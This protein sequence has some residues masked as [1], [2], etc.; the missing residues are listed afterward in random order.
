M[1][2]SSMTSLLQ[3]ELCT[4]MQRVC[5]PSSLGLAMT[6]KCYRFS[7]GVKAVVQGSIAVSVPTRACLLVA[8]TR[9]AGV[10]SSDTV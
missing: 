6:A 5:F 2:V 1:L 7:N 4:R 10:E 9:R 3:K 8:A